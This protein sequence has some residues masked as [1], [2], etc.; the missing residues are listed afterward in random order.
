MK[1]LRLTHCRSP[2]L[3]HRYR[4]S[5]FRKTHAF[6]YKK[7]KPW[8]KGEE[9]RRQN[10]WI[11]AKGTETFFVTFLWIWSCIKIKSFKKKLKMTCLG[12]LFLQ[13][14]QPYLVKLQYINKAQPIFHLSEVL[15]MFTAATVK[16]DLLLLLLHPLRLWQYPMSVRHYLFKKWNLIKIT[17]KWVC[18]LLVH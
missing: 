7:K 6:L 8:R 2:K 12:T 16:W 15:T 1:W 13:V 4:K 17:K 3:Q 18:T 9:E 10:V 5:G 14:L 11:W